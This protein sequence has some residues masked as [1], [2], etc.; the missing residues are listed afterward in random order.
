MGSTTCYPTTIQ[1][2]LDGTDDII[3]HKPKPMD[4]RTRRMLPPSD[5][6]YPHLRP[7]STRNADKERELRHR[8]L[9][10]SFIPAT[11]LETSW[12]H[13]GWKE[14]RA[15][16]LA[17]LERTGSG[18][19]SIQHFK[20]CGSDCVVEWSAELQRW[21]VSSNHCKCRHCEPC[22]RARG[23]RLV[24]NLEKRLSENPD[25][26]YRFITLTLLHSDAPLADQIK[27]L[28]ACFR[29]LRS[30]KGW[31]STQRG[32]AA[33][34]ESKF[35]LKSR[36]WHPHLHI[37]SEGDFL[38]KKKL[39]ELW[40]KATGDSYIV[41]IRKL[42][43]GKDAA[44]YV[45]KYVTKGTNAAVWFDPAAADEWVVTMRG[46]RTCLTFGT[47]RGYRLMAAPETAKD[48]KP[49]SRLDKLIAACWRNE[50]W[51][52][53]IMKGLKHPAAREFDRSE[54]ADDGQ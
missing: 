7:P 16:V 29:K 2:L 51:A 19:F 15:R 41:D 39:S 17:A 46:V 5:P 8:E 28:Y 34:L 4:L 53:A 43:R 10:L 38:D 27:R 20:E 33:I 23:T 30:M 36:Q 3:E 50:V 52:L 13:S 25:G 45:G 12:R 40:Y 1:H 35:D 42:D 11:E 26:R 32:G 47:W 22:M 18:K 14:K 54:D 44:Y 9:D 21:R 37:V 49:I 48:W 6:R 31:K 24:L